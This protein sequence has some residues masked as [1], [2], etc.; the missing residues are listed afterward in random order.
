MTCCASSSTADSLRSP[1]TCS[2]ATTSIE[3]CLDAVSCVIHR[4][5]AQISHASVILPPDMLL[6]LAFQESSRWR[7]SAF[8]LPTRSS[9]PRTSSCSEA[10]TS[11]RPS[12]VSTVSVLKC[13]LLISWSIFT[14]SYNAALKVS[15]TS[16]SGAT[17]SSC[18]RP[19]RTASTA[20]R[21]R[22]SSMRRSSAATAAS[23]PTC[24][25]W[26]RS[27]V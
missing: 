15:T 11:A 10:T 18:G 16:A 8:C 17:T 5:T 26:S 6:T 3:V 14:S 2:S 21:W 13:T 24:S 27:V 12:T 25:P 9:I 22:P 4:P 20:C 1:T 7:R 19:S 23:R